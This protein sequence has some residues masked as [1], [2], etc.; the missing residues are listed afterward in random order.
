MSDDAA[1]EE[2]L[3][4]AFAAGFWAGFKRS[5]EGFNGEYPF[6]DRGE[7]PEDHSDLVAALA[8]SAR[9]YIAGDPTE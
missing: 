8:E 6:T 5:G 9:A 2:A 1:V 4:E 7:R 3:R